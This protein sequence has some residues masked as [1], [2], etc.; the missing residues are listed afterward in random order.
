MK[1]YSLVAGVA[2]AAGSFLM[3]SCD[4]SQK[5]AFKAIDPANM[6]TTVRAQDDFYTFANG[7]WLANNPI[8]GT[9]SRW[10]SFSVLQEETNKKI[11]AVLEEAAANTKAAKGSNEQKVGDFY[12]TGMDSAAVENAGLSPLKTEL[13]RIAG[14]QSK[15]DVLKTVALY[16]TYNVNPLFVFYVYQDLKNSAQYISYCEQGGLSLPDRDYYVKNDARSV[17]IRTEY[18]AHLE[19]M[20]KLMGDDE[21]TAKANASTVMNMETRL[22]KASMTRVELRDPYASY[23]KKTITEANK[24]TPSLD[25]SK[26]FTQLGLKNTNEFVMAQPLF[27]AEVEKMLKTVP[28]DNWKT[29]LR[30]HLVGSYAGQLNDAF[31][32]ENF[33]FNGTFMNGAKEMKPRWKRVLAQ[34]DGALG[35]AL[36]EVY[37]KKYFPED[38][39]KRCLEMVNNMQTVYKERIEKLDWMSDSTK[40]RAI[41]KLN[42]FI[43]KIGYPDKWKDYSKL[44]ISRESYVQNVMNANVFAFNDMISK[45]GKPVDNTEW[46]MTP[47]TINAYYNPTINEIVFPAGILQ[48]PFFDPNVDDAINYGG[49]GAVIGHEMTHGFDDQG[50]QFDAEG[51][52]KNW[53]GSEDERR[54]KEKTTMVVNQYNAYTVLD[55]VHVNG[56]L[57]LG[58]NIADLGGIYIAYDAFKRT[59]QGQSDEKID[60]FTPDQR[61]FLG[62]AQVWR[63]NITDQ[64]LMQRIVTDPHSPGKFRSNGP[65]SNM[66][67]F[68]K[69]FDVKEGDKMWR[70]EANRAKVW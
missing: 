39:K 9:E 7:A 28:V 31:V 3:S 67:E 57:T 11:K 30:W 36:G 4:K 1:K 68:Y 33:A 15:D 58:E 12:A 41:N 45:M 64:N 20:F 47:Y 21:A 55:T 22:A 40:D 35:E 23:N 42:V 32:K 10:G 38:A 24:I 6:D 66:P 25:W 29:Y 37:V 26:H 70:P 14:I 49:I 51:N 5:S 44:E 18:V 34:V 65:L 17:E 56:E 46:G 19:R 27:F 2:I 63:Q 13:D 69:A 52:L 61:F 53:W 48:F 50:C 59:K 8:P 60:G 16:Q 54:F 62:W 43:K